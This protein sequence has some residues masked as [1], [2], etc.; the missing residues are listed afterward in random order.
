MEEINDLTYAEKMYLLKIYQISMDEDKR[1]STT[2]IAKLL[3]VKAP[4]QQIC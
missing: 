2:Q 3:E 4:S 1:I